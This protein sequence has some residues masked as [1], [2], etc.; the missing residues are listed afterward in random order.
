M[1]QDA[2]LFELGALFAVYSGPLLR[3]ALRVGI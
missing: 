3:V 1:L 2:T